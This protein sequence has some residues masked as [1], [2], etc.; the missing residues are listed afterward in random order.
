MAPRTINAKTGNASVTKLGHTA[1]DQYG[2]K[3]GAK[4]VGRKPPRD[5]SAK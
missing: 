5:L 3:P 2:N 4:A 1:N